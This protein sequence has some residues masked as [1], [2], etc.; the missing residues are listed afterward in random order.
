[1][2]CIHCGRIKKWNRAKMAYEDWRIV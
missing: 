1:M 2:S